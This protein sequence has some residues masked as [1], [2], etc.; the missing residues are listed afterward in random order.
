MATSIVIDR[1]RNIF[2]CPKCQR[3]FRT[4]E[5][6]LQ[7]CRATSRHSW[8]EQ[9]RRVCDDDS[10]LRTHLKYNIAHRTCHNCNRVFMSS[11][12]LKMVSSHTLSRRWPAIDTISTSSPTKSPVSN[13]SFVTENSGLSLA[14]SFTSKLAIASMKAMSTTGLGSSS[15]GVTSPSRKRCVG[16]LLASARTATDHSHMLVD[17]SS[18]LRVPVLRTRTWPRNLRSSCGNEKVDVE[19]VGVFL[20]MYSVIMDVKRISNSLCRVLLIGAIKE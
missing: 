7:H 19:T 16:R 4:E 3:S 20:E 17:S 8:C 18:T 6:L 12:N 10:N 5:S 14:C 13:V 11:D 2:N 15:T 1:G 9:C